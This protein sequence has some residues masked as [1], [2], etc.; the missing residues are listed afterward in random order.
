MSSPQPKVC[1]NGLIAVILITRSRPGPKLVFHY[2]AQPAVGQTVNNDADRSDSEDED[3]PAP[4]S[5]WTPASA[6]V[7]TEGV[8]KGASS[9]GPLSSSDAVDRPLTDLLLGY[10]YET[11][12]KLLSPGRWSDHIKF[13]ICLD[14]ITFVGHP[15]YAS[16]DGAWSSYPSTDRRAELH[17]DSNIEHT[18]LD[19]ND[20][21]DGIHDPAVTITGPETPGRPKRDFSQVR[22]SFDSWAG[23]SRGTSVNSTSTTS[24]APQEQISMFHVVF[25]SRSSGD[26]DAMTF[27]QHVAQTLSRALQYCQEH[28]QYISIEARKL[29]NARAAAKRANLSASALWKQMVESSELAWALKECFEKLS[30]NEVASIRLDGMQMSVQ[31]PEA[32]PYVKTNEKLNERLALLLLEDKDVLLHQLADSDTSLLAYVL[33]EHTPTKSLQKH[34]INLGLTAA[35]I[36]PLAQHLIEWRKARAIAPL[37]AR[38]TYTVHPDAPLHKV[39]ELTSLYSRKFPALP[40]LPQMLMVL[41]GKPIPYG[42]LI[43]SRD[44]RGPYMEILAFLHRHGFVGQLKT[45]GW[46]KLSTRLPSPPVADPNKRPMSAMSLLSPHLRPVDDDN[47]SVASVQTAV[48]ANSTSAREYMVVLDP[49]HITAEE[50]VLVQHLRATLQDGELRERL[51]LLLPYWNGEHAFEEIAACEGLK[52]ARVG[53]WLERLEQQGHLLTFRAL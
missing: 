34:A 6:A 14:G 48:P 40:S 29:L 27:H 49:A 41:S 10:S 25:A 4:P 37:H 53:E 28:N 13:E 18:E 15:V 43:P 30:V 16:Q 52:R 8:P 24:G 11:L 35:E 44:H 19:D 12:E 33:R 39:A 2:P 45:F 17:G 32:T 21:G 26:L 7:D 36:M 5:G 47:V 31:I 3:E 23:Q 22:D 38:N 50:N 20:E 9:D 42:H 46:L 51:P 1:G